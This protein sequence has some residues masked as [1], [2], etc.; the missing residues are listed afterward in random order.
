MDDATE[1]VD[2]LV[3]LQE[4]MVNLINQ[5]SMPLV[6]VSLVLQKHIK[7]LS[8]S[9]DEYLNQSGDEVPE[10]VSQPWPI[11]VE[12]SNSQ[13]NFSLEKVLEIVDHQR[14]DILEALIRVTLIE[15]EVSLIEGIL[16]LRAWEQL[17][18][19]QLA[20]ATGPGQLFSPL[21]I[22]ENW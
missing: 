15:I 17:A 10:R 9:L 6:E 5:L 18:R 19:T 4:R 20:Q 16:A 11:N 3:T 7:G 1:G 8:Q 22:P 13:A 14:M 12:Q 2:G 21:E